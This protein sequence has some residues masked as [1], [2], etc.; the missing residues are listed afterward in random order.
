MFFRQLV[1]DFEAMPEFEKFLS[2]EAVVSFPVQ[3]KKP[4]RLPAQKVRVP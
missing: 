3:P 2:D 1:S 4:K